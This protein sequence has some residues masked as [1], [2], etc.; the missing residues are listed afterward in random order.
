MKTRKG[1]WN[2]SK[3]LRKKMSQWKGKLQD[4]VMGETNW[5]QKTTV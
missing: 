4:C 5:N 1:L 2:K 3:I